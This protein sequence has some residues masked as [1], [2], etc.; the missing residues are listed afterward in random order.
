VEVLGV[1]PCALRIESRWGGVAAGAGAFGS[2]CGSRD[3]SGAWSAGGGASD[4]SGRPRRVVA[5]E[6]DA[7]SEG[8]ALTGEGMCIAV[9]IDVTRA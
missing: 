2:T 1:M 7:G 9:V 6:D 5:S 4:W 3:G 8:G